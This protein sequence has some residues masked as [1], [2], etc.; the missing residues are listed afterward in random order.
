VAL[1]CRSRKPEIAHLSRLLAPARHLLQLARASGSFAARLTGCRALGLLLLLAAGGV[2]PAGA[3]SRLL[4][5]TEASTLSV[6]QDGRP[7]LLL[8]DI[9]VGRY[10]GT[11]AKRRGDGQTP[12][13][14][15]R[16]VSIKPHERFHFFIAL[17]YPAVAD[18]TRGLR[19][20]LI[21]ERER[22]A[23]VQAHR[24]GELPPQHT[25]LG[26]LIGIHGIGE[27]DPEIHRR[28]NWTQGCVAVTDRQ[29]DR[30]LPWLQVGT[31]V[32]IR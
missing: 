5:D 16:V 13:G 6:L 12:L 21:S 15:Y 8:D 1:S 28:F 7:V 32:E 29:L 20:G 11:T 10:G 26:G 9:A 19:A 31:V 27:G 2:P 18:A 30:L 17:D 25:R 23:I 14:S 22:A 24:R 3:E 4:V